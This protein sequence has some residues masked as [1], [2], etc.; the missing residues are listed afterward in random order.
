MRPSYILLFGDAEW[1][2]TWYV[3]TLTA[4]YSASDYPYAVGGIPAPPV[5]LGISPPSFA[6][7]RLP[8]DPEQ[9]EQV[10][11]K[12]IAYEKN[13]PSNPE[14][15]QNASILALFQCCKTG[16]FPLGG[17]SDFDL[18][19]DQRTFVET[20]EFARNVL[21]S[22]GYTAERIYAE[23]IDPNYS[24]DPTPRRWA[25]GTDLPPDLAPESGFVWFKY[26]S[27]DAKNEVVSAFNTGRFLILEVDHG[28]ENGWKS[29]QISRDNVDGLTNGA[30]LPVVFSM[31]CSTAFFDNETNPSGNPYPS[32]A[33]ETYF[34][35]RL[36]RHASGGAIGLIGA[37]RTSTELP[38]D[39]LTRGLFDAVWPEGA[40]NTGQ[41][42]LGDILNHAK[43][44]LLAQP[45]EGPAWETA[46]HDN[47][48][49]FHVIGDPT[50]EM[51]TA[52]PGVLTAEHFVRF[53]PTWL[54]LT[55]PVEGATITASQNAEDGTVPIGRAVVKDGVATLEYVM[56]PREGL[57]IL[58]SASK[59]N[60]V[61][62]LLRPEPISCPLC[63][64]K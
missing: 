34:A 8:V 25:D 3:E 32:N 30:L 53:F 10:V 57:R 9:A 64:V 46:W 38:D 59:A 60:A 28:S 43:M 33:T 5:A 55:Y 18:G 62:V 26:E 37:T 56:A 63:D 22:H 41:R 1:V 50:L 17:V 24:K 29:W 14:F 58:F 2:P 16:D 54:E 47:V 40:G 19:W 11:D 48:Y 39:V 61:S 12:I 4:Y 21:L 42:R 35:E 45:G 6:V 13:P 15:Y 31:S 27:N 44:Y 23:Y 20:T 7:G 36:I 49:L 51:W 52:Q